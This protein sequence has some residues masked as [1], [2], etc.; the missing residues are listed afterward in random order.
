MR[1]L[2]ITSELS[3]FCQWTWRRDK[4]I[5]PFIANSG[6]FKSGYF[7]RPF[8]A[9]LCRVTCHRP[10]NAKWEVTFANC[11]RHF[12]CSGQSR[13]NRCP[14][15]LRLFANKRAPYTAPRRRA[16]RQRAFHKWLIATQIY[17]NL[18][19]A[20]MQSGS[21]ANKSENGESLCAIASVSNN[22]LGVIKCNV[23]RAIP[24]QTVNSAWYASL[25]YAV[26]L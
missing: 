10:S 25:I 4:F 24:N 23:H 19:F 5:H 7:W 8:E 22:L 13:T 12:K 11:E 20:S 6:P 21:R 14:H 18:S 3:A 1:P 15:H 26:L 16:E 17:L 2:L 9:L